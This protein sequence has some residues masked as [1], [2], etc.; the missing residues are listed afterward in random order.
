M[1]P[2]DFG[3]LP[4]SI[5]EWL[6]EV[7]ELK[8]KMMTGNALHFQDLL[9]TPYCLAL[10]RRMIKDQ[11]GE[12]VGNKKSCLP[13]N[14]S[15]GGLTQ[16]KYIVDALW[17]VDDAQLKSPISLISLLKHTIPSLKVRL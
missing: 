10:D 6:G 12:D 13:F 1:L 3:A 7:A 14:G 9:F 15:D 4:L 11:D 5:S 16:V 2:S 8:N 17:F